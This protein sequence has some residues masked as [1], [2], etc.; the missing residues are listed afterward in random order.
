MI[1][2]FRDEYRWLSN[3]AN[4][5]IN[6]NGYTYPSVEAAYQAQKSDNLYW[7][8]FC[9]K[10]EPGLIKKSSRFVPL[11]P[12]WED[13]KI[14]IM[15]DLLRIKFNKEPY[16]TLLLQTG[17]KHLQEGNMWNDKFWGVC[18]KTNKGENFLGKLIMKIREDL[19]NSK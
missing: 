4:V 7:K 5:E 2:E 11:V 14:G 16:K 17:N 12:N 8:E 9:T 6:Y 18:L 3:F 13:Q 19:L 10:N 15:S 1:K